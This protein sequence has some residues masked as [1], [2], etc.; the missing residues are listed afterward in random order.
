MYTV[1]SM[2][3]IIATCVRWKLLDLP[4]LETL[5]GESV[6]DDIQDSIQM[7]AECAYHVLT[8]ST[9]GKQ[10]EIWLNWQKEG[11]HVY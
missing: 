11:V 5:L 3:Q 1:Y 7:L 2:L 4:G 9:Y 10:K 8:S 6:P